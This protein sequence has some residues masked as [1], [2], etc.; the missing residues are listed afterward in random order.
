MDKDLSKQLKRLSSA[1][2]ELGYYKKELVEEQVR[3]DTVAE[4]RRRQQTQVIEESRAMI[5]NTVSRLKDAMAE[6]KRHMVEADAVLAGTDA[7]IEIQA[8]LDA[9]TSALQCE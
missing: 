7:A 1:T 5:E 4:D 8:A 3:L 9:A 2:N 6:V